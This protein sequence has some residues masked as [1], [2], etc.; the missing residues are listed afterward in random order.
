MHVIFMSIHSIYCDTRYI[1]SLKI[2][3]MSVSLSCVLR[4]DDTSM[5]HPISKVYHMC[6]FHGLEMVYGQTESSEEEYKSIYY[7]NCLYKKC[8]QIREWFF[9]KFTKYLLKAS[10][11][12]VD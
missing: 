11:S 9:Q 8:L 4:Y 7:R 6:I 5:Y 12:F 1:N 3:S 2:V 10:V